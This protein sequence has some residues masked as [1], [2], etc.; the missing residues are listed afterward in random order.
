MDDIADVTRRLLH[1][2]KSGTTDSDDRG[3]L[4]V[5]AAT[6][7]DPALF[8]RE[9]RE[10]FGRTPQLL[11]F[12]SDISNTGD[13]LTHD[14]LGIPLLAVRGRD[15]RARVFVNACS[16]RATRLVDGCGSSAV[17][18]TCPYHAWRFD[19]QG[20]LAAI[21]AEATFGSVDRSRYGLLEIP[22][23][24]CHG[25][26]FA[27]PAPDQNCDAEK[28][29]GD[30]EEQLAFFALA[31]SEPVEMKSLTVRAN[32]KLSLDTF[33]EGYHFAT[34]HRDTLARMTLSNI[35]TY[36]RFGPHGEHH[37]LGYPAKTLAGLVG[38]PECEWGDTYEHFG[39]VYFIHPNVSMLISSRYVDVFRVYPGKT[40][41]EQTTLYSIY[42]R[43][44][45]ADAA[46]RQ[47][48]LEYFQFTCD[49]VEREDFWVTEREQRNLESGLVESLTFGRNEPALI[50]L[51]YNF[52][53]A[54]GL[55]S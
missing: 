47:E 40:P 14:A 41:G 29:L 36:D 3:P 8:E 18:F 2:I 16:H 48:A 27:N 28:H 22:S 34:L 24:E 35:T 17:G 54:L 6:Y 52:R 46:A 50:Q 11:C 25:L 45:L 30:L 26:L 7:T 42:A 5:P 39:F 15:G 19:T 33:S 4:T 53:R 31:A 44:S 20:A 13:Y 51:H 1:H 9:R 12:G 21:N 37:R 55:A 10:I 23:A 38:K 32:W 49:V 43:G